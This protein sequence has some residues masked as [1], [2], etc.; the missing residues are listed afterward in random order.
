MMAQYFV[1]S[2]FTCKNVQYFLEEFLADKL[3]NNKSFVCHNVSVCPSVCL[4]VCE[5]GLFP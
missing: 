2:I 3:N 5:Q 4:F 1:C